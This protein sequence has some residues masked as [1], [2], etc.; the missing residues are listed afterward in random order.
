[1]RLGGLLKQRLP[2]AMALVLLL[3]SASWSETRS[4]GPKNS[5]IRVLVVTGGHDFERIPFFKMWTDLEGIDY[6][7]VAQP[8]AVSLFG[9]EL[10]KKFDAIVFY[11]MVEDI[12]EE[13]KAAFVNLMKEGVGILFLHHS[14][15][16]YQNW[17]EYE[18]ILGGKYYLTAAT[19]D[20]KPHEASTYQHDVEVPVHVVD[21]KHPVTRGVSDFILH[22]EVYGKCEVLPDMHP[23]LE[24]SHPQSSKTI[25]WWHLYGKSRIVFIQPGHDHWAYENPVYRKLVKQAIVWVSGRGEK[26]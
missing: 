10:K 13:E 24:T 9:P 26:D 17:D 19:K 8:G 12:S 15:S 16:S 21:P 25:A 14:L 20:G 18:K 4:Q 7:E 23:L 11:D 1:M 6:R 5:T 2:V 3:T 22:D